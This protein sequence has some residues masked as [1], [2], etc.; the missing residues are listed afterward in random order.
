MVVNVYTEKEMISKQPNFT[1]NKTKIEEYTLTKVN[2]GKDIIQS[3][4]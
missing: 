3:L 4:N 2:R 1:S